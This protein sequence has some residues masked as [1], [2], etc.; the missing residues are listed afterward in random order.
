M[1]AFLGVSS[2]GRV[3]GASDAWLGV[4][5]SVT[6]SGRPTEEQSVLNIKTK[7]VVTNE[8]GAWDIAKIL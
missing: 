2:A 8:E 1:V 4:F 3:G 5:D 6:D 7:I